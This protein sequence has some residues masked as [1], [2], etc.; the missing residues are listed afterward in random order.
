MKKHLLIVTMVMALMLCFSCGALADINSPYGTADKDTG[1]MNDY[2][3]VG[4]DSAQKD[5][6]VSIMTVAQ[7]RAANSISDKN[8]T[9]FNGGEAIAND[10]IIITNGT[11]AVVLA[12]GTRNPWGYPAGSVLDAGVVNADGTGVRDTTWSIE[13]LPDWWDSWSP[14]NCGTVTFEMTHYDFAAKTE[15]ATG[16]LA[17]KVSRVYDLEGQYGATGEN[18]DK[19]M[20]VVTYYGAPQTGSY[21]YMYDSLANTGAD[22]IW[23]NGYE[24]YTGYQGTA[25]GYENIALS[26]TNKG[27]DGAA[28]FGK[29]FANKAVGSY[30]N[31]IGKDGYEYQGQYLTA[32]VLT[33]S[34]FVSNQGNKFTVSGNGGKSGYQE[35]YLTNSSNAEVEASGNRQMFAKGESVT[36]GEYIVV[37]DKADHAVLNNFIFAKQSATTVPVAVNGITG[38]TGD[39]EVIVYNSKDKILGWYTIDAANGGSI[40]LPAGDYS[41][42]VE[43]KGYCTSAKT[44]FTVTATGANAITPALGTEKVTIHV[45]VKEKDTGDALSA[46]IGVYNS[47][48]VAYANTLYPTV[49]Y[50]G[51]SVY[52]TKGE[53]TNG[54]N[55]EVPKDTDCYLKVMGEGYFFTSDPVNVKVAASDAVASKT[56]EVKVDEVFSNDSDWLSGDMHHHTNKNDAFALPSDVVDSQR[57]SGLDVAVTTDHDYT[58]NNA[59][60]YDYILASNDDDSIQAYVP[61]VEISCSWAHFNVLP[62][63]SACWDQYLDRD[64]SNEAKDDNGMLYAFTDLKYFV[65]NISDRGASVTANHPWYSYGLFTALG[66]DAIPGGYV[67]NYGGLGLNGSYRDQE[68]SKTINSGADLWNAY[69]DYLNSGKKT[70]GTAT[71]GGKKVEVSNAHY[72]IGG[73]DTHDVFTPYITN[74]AETS[75]VLRENR[76][77]FYTGKV[78]TTAY[79]SDTDASLKDNGIEY[80]QSVV[81]GNS[82]VTT[83]P[84]LNLSDVPGSYDSEDVLINHVIDSYDLSIDIGSLSG[85]RDII[86]M[87]DEADGTYNAYTGKAD[88]NT[89]GVRFKRQF[90]LSHVDA[91]LSVANGISGAESDPTLCAL[92]NSTS[93]LKSATFNLSYAPSSEGVHWVSVCIVDIYGNYAVTNPYWVTTDYFTDCSSDAWYTEALLWSMENYLVQGYGDGTYHPLSRITRA[94][95][96][97]IVYNTLVRF[98]DDGAIANKNAAFPDVTKGA[99]Y[100]D[101]ISY[102]AQRGYLNGYPDG[103]FKPNAPI[104]RAE[105]ATVLSNILG[106]YDGQWDGRKYFNDVQPGDWYYEEIM[107]LAYSHI[108]SGYGNQMFYPER[109]ANRVEALQMIFKMFEPEKEIG[110]EYAQ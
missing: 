91:D 43:K 50:C 47:N 56:I 35:L 105:I 73:S 5:G 102:M 2:K 96:C 25:D 4:L 46:K 109:Y 17:V 55:V 110:P 54:V 37:S 22:A 33:D 83:G 53:S 90:S 40:A 70:A 3:V 60:A 76:E 57:A 65:N 63:T 24:G 31:T 62:L 42:K 104:T 94:E 28:M 34:E 14:S 92:T 10:D 44:A 12:V 67:D 48:G 79:V 59:E 27:N 84:I 16:D 32:L 75:N 36:F 21:L 69:R 87:T 78:R 108:V 68:M 19:S 93:S 15:S 97:T 77:E 61:S 8:T 82:Y 38:A 99:W 88:K 6:N 30:A 86:V 1:Y 51:N 49:R 45:N 107:S 20:S 71:I 95:Y 100:Y 80:A 29:N 101:A 9:F 52:Q 89:L 41:Y 64:K 98:G 103:T 81:N 23:Y 11:A 13:F 74:T 85:I 26:V 7:W 58:T 18:N 66:K 72:F 39:M 106:T